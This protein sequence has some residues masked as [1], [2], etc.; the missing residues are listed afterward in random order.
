MRLIDL[1]GPVLDVN[2]KRSSVGNSYLELDGLRGIAVLIVL[3]SHSSAFGMYGQGSLGVLLFFFLSGF[4]LT[5]PFVENPMKIRNTDAVTRFTLNRMLRIVPAYWVACVVIFIWTSSPLEWLLWNMS[6]V[7]GWN[8]FWSVAE[9]VRFYI[10]FPF[11]ILLL[12]FIKQRFLQIILI[13]G[14]IL[15]FY[16]YRDF[17]KIDMMS[18]GKSVGL[19][20]WMFLGGML[21]CFLHKLEFL[22]RIFLK[23][24][25]RY[26]MQLL[27][28]IVL[29]CLVMSSTYMIDGFWRPLVPTIPAGFKLNGW[30]SPGF[31]FFM[32]LSLFLSCT[33]A[34]KG[35]L[36][37]FVKL[38]FFRHVGL[39][40]YSIYIIHMNIQFELMSKGFRAEKLF[41]VVLCL[42]YLYSYCSY[43]FLEKPF[44]AI[45]KNTR[46]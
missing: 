19:Y 31:W 1:I 2:H 43:V 21:A 12:S 10:L 5:L 11:V 14:L 15:L 18:H 28:I 45:K 41:F 40:S 36:N 24:L 29:L 13:V 30:S 7:K 8:H 6:F 3:M 34:S 26:A 16:K 20:F 38:W 39:L 44:L 42:A 37:L 33:S 17:H 4:V 32:F 23:P 25:F 22:E 27:G 9:E 35:P 46:N